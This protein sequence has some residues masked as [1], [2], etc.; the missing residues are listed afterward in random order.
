LQRRR[1]LKIEARLVVEQWRE[2]QSI[3]H[4]SPDAVTMLE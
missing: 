1:A 3:Q 2:A 4:R